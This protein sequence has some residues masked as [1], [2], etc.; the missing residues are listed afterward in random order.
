MIISIQ[1]I[2]AEQT[3]PL[4]Q[5]VMY[6]EF[7]IGQVKLKDDAAGRHFGLFLGE[8]LT[9]VV[10]VFIKDQALQFRKLATKTD[11]QGNGYGRQMMAFILNL[12]SA[13]NLE[14]VWCNAR[15]TAAPFYR[16][17]GFEAFGETWQQ[18][19][20]AFVVMQKQILSR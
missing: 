20:H 16:Q 1:P 7:S 10:S 19:G 2:A 5:S 8:E 9:V 15:L 17:F 12:A 14:T 6:P 18:D 3:W 4:R 13:E 11:Q